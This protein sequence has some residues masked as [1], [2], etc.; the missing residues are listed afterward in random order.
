MNYTIRKLEKVHETPIQDFKL[1]KSHFEVHL[2][3]TYEEKPWVF[4]NHVHK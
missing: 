1:T 2:F 4:S 3:M